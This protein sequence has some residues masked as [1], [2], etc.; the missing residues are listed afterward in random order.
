M[1]VVPEPSQ[2]SEP[3]PD[4]S[5]GGED[6][7]GLRIG[8]ALIDLALLLVLFV[9]LAVLVGEASV[10][11]GAFSFSLDGF[12]FAVYVAL[13]LLY[14]LVLEAAIGQTVGKLLVGL[15][16]VRAGGGRP[17]VLHVAARTLVRVVD[18][19]PALYLVG[20][21]AMLATGARRQRLGDLAANTRIARA[22]PMRHRGL[23]VAGLA[24]SLVLVLAGSVVYVA[25]SDQDEGAQ[26]YRGN[27]VSFDYPAGWEEGTTESR[28]ET[29]GDELWEVA[30][31]LDRES[32]VTV[33]AYRLNMPVTAENL[34]AAKAEFE[35]VVRELVDQ[36]GGTVQA[37]PEQITAAGN[38][39]LRFRATAT[40]DGTSFES[41]LVFIFDDA[42]EYYLNCQY[43]A[44]WAEEIERGCE[45]I[46]RTFTVDMVETES[47]VPPAAE[48]PAPTQAQETAAPGAGEVDVFDL[49]V[50]DC[51]ADSMPTGGEEV[52][53][54]ETVPCSE[55]HSE[56]VYAV[57]TLP[58]G[59]FPGDEA[60]A[61]QADEVC[62]A[63]FESFVGLPYEESVLYY[64][65]LYPSD[66]Q[67]W[68]GGYRWA[69][70]SV[71]DPAGEVRGSLR[72]VQ[73]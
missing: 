61:A 6:L 68:N 27:G 10:G 2:A 21:I 11:G 44:E 37:G 48:T 45:Q 13:A 31:V 40:V 14:Y 35:G 24:S 56:E 69:T 46:V 36:L 3:G 53:T 29:G 51:L 7:L 64:N 67:S 12:E 63:E 55:P 43:T 59:D 72:G 4:A 25:A 32:L 49:K 8:A 54:V 41:T 30:F 42:T 47:T 39:G 28:A 9:V 65:Y 71:Y 66:E 5:V 34:D 22:V 20:F 17:N 38:L 1:S 57:V 15:R 26:T 73:R 52:F 18:W 23:A 33:A 60:V 58:E 70:C 19:L 62:N 16:V 50:R